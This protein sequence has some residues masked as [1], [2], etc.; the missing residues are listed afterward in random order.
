VGELVRGSTVG[1]GSAETVSALAARTAA[2]IALV[3]W[4]RRAAAPMPPPRLF[5]S[6]AAGNAAIF[7]INAPLSAAVFLMPQ[8]QQVDARQ[9]AL[10]SRLRLLA[11]G[12]APFLIAPRAGADRIGERA[13]V[14][15]GVSLQAGGMAWIAAAVRATSGHP[16]LIAPMTLVGVGFAVAIPAVTQ[17]VTSTAP[18]SDIGKGSGAYNTTRQPGGAFGVAIPAAA[19]IALAGVAAALILPRRA[20]RATSAPP[21]PRLPSG[22]AQAPA[23]STRQGDPERLRAPPPPPPR[24]R[25]E[26]KQD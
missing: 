22:T 19:G 25:A 15:T 23:D 18:L 20:N 24:R 17:A 11:W 14:V 6:P 13:L 1:W 26:G 7:L 16:T 5:R 12:I 21:E 10:S 3:A 2:G 8:F 9:G 4:E